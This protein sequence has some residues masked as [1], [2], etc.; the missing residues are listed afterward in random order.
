MKI[1][2][3]DIKNEF[4][5]TTTK[6]ALLF[7]G[8]SSFLMPGNEASWLPLINMALMG[9]MYLIMKSNIDEF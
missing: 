4:L 6:A 3:E 9:W 1:I 8:L 7:A 2:K 5:K